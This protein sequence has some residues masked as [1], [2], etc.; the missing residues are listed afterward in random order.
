[1]VYKWSQAG[2]VTAEMD[3]D[4]SGEGS[5]DPYIEPTPVESN[6]DA[7]SLWLVFGLCVFAALAVNVLYHCWQVKPDELN[8][9]LVSAVNTRNDDEDEDEVVFGRQRPPLRLDSTV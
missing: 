2:L 4:D 6:G 5:A 9:N 7:V 1:M 8:E 3:Y